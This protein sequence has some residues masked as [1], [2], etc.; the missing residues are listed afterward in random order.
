MTIFFKRGVLLLLLLFIA[1]P[2]TI[3]AQTK[4]SSGELL[5]GVQSYNIGDFVGAEKEFL[6]IISKDPTNDAAYYY[7]GN[8]YYYANE[9]DLAEKY[10]RLAVEKDRTNYWYRIKLAQFYANTDRVEYA[11]ALYE[12]LKN[13]Y[14]EKNSLY[15]DIISLYISS[16][17]IDEALKTLDV[18]ENTK[19][20]NEATGHARYELLMRQ[21][22]ADEANLFL[23]NFEKEY[24][25]PQT[26]FIL[27]DLYKNKFIDTTAVKYY[28]KALAMDPNYTPAYY[29]LAEVYRMKRQ[30]PEYFRNIN[31]FMS[32]KNM[33][34]QTKV[35]YI[36][37][38]VMNPQFVQVFMPQIDTIIVNTIA[39]HPTDSA[40]ITVAAQYYIVT[41]RTEQGKALYLGNIAN[42][43]TDLR[44]N[45]DYISLLYYLKEWESLIKHLV[46][47]I[48]QFDNEPYLYELL[49]VAYWQNEDYDNSI[50]TYLTILKN[51]GK[52]RDT[53]LN[54]YA[55][56][57]DLYH[58]KNNTRKSFK[59]Y[60]KA[61]K[62]Y[63]NYNPVLN[64]YA[65]YLSLENKK[66]KKALAM[67][68]KTIKTEPDNPTYLDTY[69]WILYLLGDYDEAKKYFKHAMLYGGKESAVMLDHYAD[70][71][72]AL[73]EYDL[74]LIYW[75]Q[76]S[77]LDNTLGI[78]QKI[79]EKKA[80]IK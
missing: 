14:P 63:P 23:E 33:Y 6:A 22:K 30:F 7:L 2:T 58:L 13:D 75:E 57:G 54:C 64:N 55:A 9:I 16:N 28:S 60:E 48:A 37:E 66:L 31:I 24:P 10:L 21:G 78:E 27:G 18:I 72:F 76:A 52:N 15:Y 19:G 17:Q 38:V 79:V 8:I 20:A 50:E 11:I 1:L 69:A 62:I 42:Y 74:A 32:D 35:R 65:Y 59:Y 43:P 34:S 12:N 5:Q 39:A 26:A 29:G 40:V 41:Q 44:V 36:R 46:L 61:L 51:S 77:K 68:Q 25:S 71:L 53:Q 56:L 47:C 70:V 3:S 45:S 73:K 4:D 67:S 49:A 80:L